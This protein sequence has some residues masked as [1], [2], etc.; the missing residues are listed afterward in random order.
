MLRTFLSK[1]DLKNFVS[2]HSIGQLSPILRSYKTILNILHF[3][4]SKVHHACEW[5]N[6]SR[7]YLLH[8][9]QM[10]TIKIYTNDIKYD[11]LFF[12]LD[13]QLYA[14]FQARM[15]MPKTIS[16]NFFPSF[17]KHLSLRFNKLHVVVT[18][19]QNSFICIITLG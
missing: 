12:E 4:S 17:Q 11:L 3:I 19:C 6:L 9:L 14:I 15:L 8:C 2:R 10:I 16:F 1:F 5:N 18:V 13:I 7:F